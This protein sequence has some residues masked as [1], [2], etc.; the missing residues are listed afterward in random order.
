MS[1]ASANHPLLHVWYID[2]IFAVFET[3]KSY[4]NF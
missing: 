4:L 1:I 3:N 2:D